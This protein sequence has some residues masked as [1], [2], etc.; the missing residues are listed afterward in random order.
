[1][2]LPTKVIFLSVGIFSNMEMKVLERAVLTFS[3]DSFST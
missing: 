2:C 3:W 1:M